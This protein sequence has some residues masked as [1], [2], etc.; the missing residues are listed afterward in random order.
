MVFILSDVFNGIRWAIDFFFTKTPRPVQILV[1]LLLI[2]SFGFIVSFTMHLLGIHCTSAK[3]VVSTSWN[4]FGV[5][6]G[7]IGLTDEEILIGDNKS[8]CDAHHDLCSDEHKCFVYA[9]QVDVDE[10]SECNSTDTGCKYLYKYGNCFNCTTQELCFER[11]IFGVCDWDE[12]C[13]TDV[14][15]NNFGEGFLFNGCFANRWDAQDCN[16]PDGYFWNVTTGAYFCT[17]DD[18]CGTNATK[19]LPLL[20]QKLEV[21]NAQLFYPPN[22]DSESY[23]KVVS[24]TCDNNFNPQLAFF[25]IPLFNYEIWLLLIVIYV[26]GMFTFMFIRK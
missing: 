17:D 11:R 5:N 10:W 7:I 24:I 14:L 13:V 23:K 26:V 15:G 6:L 21:A 1:F 19:S 3:E 2:V 12:Y 20:D 22:V 8:I 16:I 9:N 25:S 4:D 18:I